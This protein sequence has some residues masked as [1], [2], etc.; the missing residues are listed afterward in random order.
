MGI[1]GA[2]FAGKILILLFSIIVHE[3]FHGLAALYY[4]DTTA[5]RMGRLTLN[6]I[7]H[8][9]L[10]GSILLPAIGLLYGGVIFGW[11]KPVPV[12]PLNFRKIREGELVVSLAGVLSNLGLAIIAAVVYHLS[13]AF[14][15][16]LVLQALMVNAVVLNLL[17]MVF[18][19]VPIPP[20]DGSKVL[21]T[22]LPANLEIK[23]RKLEQY[24][25]LILMFIFFTPVGTPLRILIF[26]LVRFLQNILI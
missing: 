5:K 25:F 11:A 14:F 2:L 6:P 17:L 18:N 13:Q 7:P 10:V 15:P 24:G 26:S 20:L 22:F 12:N 8:I 23:F 19:M 9:D 1:E 16:S 21:M 3:V 4:G